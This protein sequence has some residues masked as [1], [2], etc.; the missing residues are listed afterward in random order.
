MTSDHG[1]GFDAGVIADSNLASHDDVVFDGDAAGEAGLGRDDDIFSD[2]TV[3]ADVDEVVNFCALADA[4]LV[5]G[6]A[7]DGGVSS[8]FD[9]VFEDE[10]TDLRG[11]LVA[12]GVRIADVAEA[13]AAEDGSSL[14]Y[15]AIAET[16]SG[17]DGDVGIDAAVGADFDV[18]ADYRAGSDGRFVSD[19]CVFSDY[20]ARADGYVLADS[21]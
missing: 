12:S 20:G 15:D 2:Q 21:R 16:D 11:L 8:D 3:V 13:F 10:T 9:V 7:V 19:F 4:S 1:A 6:P 17:I 18:V 5:E 14:D